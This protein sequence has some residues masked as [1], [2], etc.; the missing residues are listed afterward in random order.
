MIQSGVREPARVRRGER[1]ARFGR[2]VGG[3]GLDARDAHG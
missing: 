3:R 1:D 2:D